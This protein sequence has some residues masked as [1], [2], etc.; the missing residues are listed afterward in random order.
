MQLFGLLLD[1]LIHI[2]FQV[3]ME[4]LKELP[5]DIRRQ[6]EQDMKINKRKSRKETTSEHT[7]TS[8]A[9][10]ISKPQTVLYDN[11]ADNDGAQ[12]GCSN[13]GSLVV[14]NSGKS[15]DFVT[16]AQDEIHDVGCVQMFETTSTC[17]NEMSN[18]PRNGLS[19]SQ[20][21]FVQ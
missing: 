10:N 12:P 16:I 1:I 8:V 21:S 7:I 20:V 11:Y 9:R 14:K 4:V 19:Y 6:I 18:S 5:D 17:D 3:D 2:L 15:P 13:W